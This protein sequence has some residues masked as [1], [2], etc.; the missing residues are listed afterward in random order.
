MADVRREIKERVKHLPK[1]INSK[2]K[3]ALA[4]SFFLLECH[5]KML[6]LMHRG[7]GR[8]FML[9]F[10][11]HLQ[12]SLYILVVLHLRHMHS[13]T[14]LLWQLWAV[15]L[16]QGAFVEFSI[17]AKKEE[18]RGRLV[19]SQSLFS[20]QMFIRSCAEAQSMGVSNSACLEWINIP[21]LHMQ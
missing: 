3:T 6:M 21:L 4:F 2:R 16:Q 7:F 12:I 9:F 15:G 18:G 20:N 1:N 11:L 19:L 5:W 17:H 13:L 14:S 8:A 10:H